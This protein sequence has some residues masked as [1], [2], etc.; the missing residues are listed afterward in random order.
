MFVWPQPVAFGFSVTTSRSVLT[1]PGTKA[2]MAPPQDG[3]G[4]RVGPSV[5]APGCSATPDTTYSRPQPAHRASRSNAATGGYSLPPSPPFRRR[6]A[7]TSRSNRL[8]PDATFA[9]GVLR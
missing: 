6:N 8:P 7:G 5:S 1:L 2:V 9:F 4:M 3:Q